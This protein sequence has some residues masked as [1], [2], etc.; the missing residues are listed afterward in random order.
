MR[1]LLTQQ[2]AADLLS[3]YHK[4]LIVE[5]FDQALIEVTKTIDCDLQNSIIHQ[6]KVKP[7]LFWSYVV[8]FAS[9]NSAKFEDFKPVIING[10]FGLLYHD[11]LF[12]RFKKVNDMF[13][14]SNIPTKQSKAFN[15]QYEIDGLANELS[16]LTAAYRINTTW[17]EFKSINIICRSGENILWNTDLIN[18]NKS[19]IT[20][21]FEVEPNQNVSDNVMQ[22]LKIREGI[23]QRK[24][25]NTQ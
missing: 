16:I 6:Q 2:E 17:T 11:L 7:M 24:K 20:K 18:G 8:H 15:Y 22:L 4:S 13:L 5:T 19:K 12:I 1:T 23:V 9:L 25:N 10:V 21:L 3:P 14:S